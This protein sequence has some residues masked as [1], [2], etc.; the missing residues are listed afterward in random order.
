MS[1]ER[2]T[3]GG[4]A[5]PNNYLYSFNVYIARLRVTFLRFGNDVE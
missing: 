2:D 3:N 5:P 4:V 1:R